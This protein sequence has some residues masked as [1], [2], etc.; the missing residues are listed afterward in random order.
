MKLFEPIATTKKNLPPNLRWVNRL[1]WLGVALVVA[2][3]LI[4]LP[5]LLRSND[6]QLP[7]LDN[8]HNPLQTSGLYPTEQNSQGVLRW[9]EPTATIDLPSTLIPQQIN[10]KL[11]TITDT[12]TVAQIFYNKQQIGSLKI[13]S[14]IKEYQLSISKSW[15]WQGGTLE[16]KIS[17]ALPVTTTYTNGRGVEL[18]ALS[19][20]AAPAPPISIWLVV[21]LL[22]MT[23]FWAGLRFFPNLTEALNSQILSRRVLGFVFLVNV[24]TLLL[25]LYWNFDRIQAAATSG[26]FTLAAAWIF[27]LTLAVSQLFPNFA[28]WPQ[29]WQR[30]ILLGLP[31][32]LLIVAVSWLYGQVF[33][34]NYGFYWDDYHIARPWT[35]NQ[36]TNVFVGTW[37]PLHFEPEYYRPITAV[38]F[39][40]DYTLWG[41]NAFGYHLTNLLLEIGVALSSYWLLRRLAIERTL[42]FVIS[43]LVF[44]LPTSADATVWISERSDS[45]ALLFMLLSLI[46]FSYFW[47]NY[48]VENKSRK[49]FSRAYI[50]AN[51]AFVLALGSKETGVILPEIWLL[52]AWI[53]SNQKFRAKQLLAWSVPAFITVLYLIFRSSVIQ[54]SSQSVTLQDLWDGYVS[55]V[56]QS[57]WVFN[58]LLGNIGKTPTL[59]QSLFVLALLAIMLGYLVWRGRELLKAQPKDL[60]NGWKLTLFGLGWLLLGC[61]PLAL[62]ATTYGIDRRVLYASGFGYALL[63]GGF[64]VSVFNW[65]Q[66]WKKQW[67]L[68]PALIIL[69]VGSWLIFSPL[70]EQN[71]QAQK[72]YAPYSYE[73]LIWDLWILHNPAWIKQIPAT[74]VEFI[75]QKLKQAGQIN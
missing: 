47:Q 5:Y 24:P 35:A 2:I 13:A 14:Q 62:L 72:N 40:L 11:A 9:T 28:D 41:L 71:Q 55:A 38:S 67:Q 59:L 66:S 74:Q 39:A 19:E 52:W 12:N 48:L 6:F 65:L 75:Q 21:C 33:I 1:L 49:K 43:G 17:P 70:V 22:I 69:V 16:I 26:E 27:L 51:L 34:A 15:Q 31:L 58:S 61:A 32:I 29:L 42:A 68:W 45:L 50:L 63:I 20:T 36:L 57:C 8:E 56:T 10:L 18:L 60:A 46:A 30:L 3:A 4:W 73:T 25:T 23:L 44:L 53:Y 54:A 64:L 37:D 7:V